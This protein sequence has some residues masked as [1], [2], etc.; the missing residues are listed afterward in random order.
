MRY[1]GAWGMTLALLVAVG[2]TTASAGEKDA[3]GTKTAYWKS[4]TTWQVMAE[5]LSK[6]KAEDMKTEARGKQKA[7]T[8]A[9]V[10]SRA[11]PAVDP[12]VR[13]RDR[14]EEAFLRRSAVCLKLQEIALRTNDDDLLRRAEQLS[15][16]AWAAYEQRQ[17][18]SEDDD[19]AAE[20]LLSQAKSGKAGRATAPVYSVKGKDAVNPAAGQEDKR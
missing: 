15:D 7:E 4:K 14:E 8:P 10:A 11:T 20:K 12:A 2:S 19:L 9:K 18:L 1:L 13:E 17:A 3:K 16:K 6:E 5:M